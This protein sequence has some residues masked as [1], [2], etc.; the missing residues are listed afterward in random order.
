MSTIAVDNARPSAGG[1]SYSLTSGVAKA[2]GVL[3]YATFSGLESYNISGTTDNGV[4]SGT[5]SFTNSFS[6]VLY[7]IPN[8]TTAGPVSSSNSGTQNL[9]RAT[10]SFD[11][12]AAEAGSLSDE[13]V[14]F[15]CHGDL[16]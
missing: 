4:G 13:V 9:N 15:S 11:F 3:N 1:T 6:G 7:S 16:A 10:G 14:D 2:W 8:G 5:W 12:R